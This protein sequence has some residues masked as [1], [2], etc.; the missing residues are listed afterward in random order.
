MAGKK[1]FHHDSVR[2]GFTL[3][4]LL[5]SAGVLSLVSVIIAQVIFTTVR[6]SARTE[7]M[8]EMKQTGGITMETVKRMVQNAKEISSVCDGTPKSELTLVNL[9]GGETTLSCLKDT[10]YTAYDIYRIASY[11]S[12]LDTTSYLTSGN[13]TL[14]TSG[15]NA[16]CGIADSEDA[17]VYFTC[18]NTTSVKTV[19]RF[20]LRN[21]TTG[22]FEGDSEIFESVTSV[23]NQ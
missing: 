1:K 20:R 8:K 3:L 12:V 13:V 7:L 21:A 17:S 23:R 2:S 15:G 16:G 6:L 4:E 22:I 18:T 10:F 14:V 19:F 5:V 11:S 9:D